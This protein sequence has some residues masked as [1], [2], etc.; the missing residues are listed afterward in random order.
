MKSILL[1]FVSCLLYVSVS[2]QSEF[3]LKVS[4]EVTKELS[5]SLA[6]L[7][8]MPHQNAIL[9]DRNGKDYTYSGVPVQDILKAAGVTVGKDLQGENLSKYLL[10]KC[11]DGYQVLFSLAELDNSFSNKVAIIADQSEGKA[12][13]EAKGPLRFVMPGENKP[14]RSCFQVVELEVEFAK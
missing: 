4:G 9:K 6:D 10:V 13:P 2:A 14:A 3:R 8:K 5:L 11:A 1:F 7:Q 12:L